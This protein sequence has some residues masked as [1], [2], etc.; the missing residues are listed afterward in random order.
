MSGRPSWRDLKQRLD[1]VQFRPSRRLGQNFLTDDG[2]CLSIAQCAEIERGEFVLE[3]GVGPGL[4]THH[5]L[6]AGGRVLGVEIDDRLATVAED[7]LP[8][9]GLELLRHDAL[10]GKHR[11]AAPL[12]ERLP[13]AGEPWQLVANLPYA[14]SVPLLAL[15]AELPAPPRRMTALVQLEVAERLLASP[16]AREF[17]AATVVVAA[18]YTGRLV[19]RVPPVMFRPRPKVDSAVVQ[20]ER[21]PDALSPERLGRVGRLAAVLFTQRRKRAR[22]PLSGLVDGVQAADELLDRVVG[23]AEVRVEGLGIEELSMLA[24]A[25]GEDRL[26]RPQ[27]TR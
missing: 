17:G 16:G 19:R 8:P 21:R 18:A 2:V 13:A 27:S 7:W 1:Q 4:L 10:N 25:L 5:L 12:L 3:I 6:Q 24:E 22:H 11:L 23:D 9:E 14:I 15:L 20:F 26:P